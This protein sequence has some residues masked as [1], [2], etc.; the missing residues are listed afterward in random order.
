VNSLRR[1]HLSASR[2]PKISKPGNANLLSGDFHKTIQENGILRLLAL[3]FLAL[4]AVRLFGRTFFDYGLRRRQP[5]NRDTERRRAHVVHLH[6]VAEL[7]AGR[8][9]SM[10]AADSDL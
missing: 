9:S 10:F 1:K 5:G 3:L 7:Y 2:L 4:F 6:F 8:I